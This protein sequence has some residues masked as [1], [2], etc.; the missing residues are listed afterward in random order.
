M[1]SSCWD[2]DKIDIYRQNLAN[3]SSVP[4]FEEK[5]N[6]IEYHDEN[7][8]INEIVYDPLFLRSFSKRKSNTSDLHKPSG[9]AWNDDERGH[10]KDFLPCE[11]QIYS[12]SMWCQKIFNDLFTSVVNHIGF[13][14]L[15]LPDS[16]IA[17]MINDSMSKWV[18]PDSLKFAQVFSLFKKKD[19]LIKTNYRPVTILV[20]L[21]KTFWKSHWMSVDGLFQFYFFNFISAF[22]KGTSCQSGLLN[23][24]EIFKRALNWD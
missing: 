5:L 8:D 21:S 3:N 11:R 16:A 6:M 23:M 19:K 17:K 1:T 10:V 24:T 22:R 7:T 20:A 14:G 12:L 15:I 9:R 2:I 13:D 4:K 18:F